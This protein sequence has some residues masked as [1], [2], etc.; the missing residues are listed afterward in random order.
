MREQQLYTKNDSLTNAD[1]GTTADGPSDSYN[2]HFEYDARVECDAVFPDCGRPDVAEW[3][4]DNYKKLFSIRLDFVWHDMTVP[5][6]MPHK[7]GDP[8]GKNAV[9]AYNDCPNEN[10]PFDGRYN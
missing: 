5:A 10:D 9:N 3:W 8:V 4:G 2:G 1:F 6:M 7:L